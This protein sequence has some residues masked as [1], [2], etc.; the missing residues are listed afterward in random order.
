MQY[1]ISFS[2]RS[3]FLMNSWRT[4]CA[5]YC[6]SVCWSC[7][8]CFNNAAN[9]KILNPSLRPLRF[10]F[11]LYT[12]T[13]L[14]FC[15]AFWNNFT[16]KS[17]FQSKCKQTRRERTVLN[18]KTRSFP[19]TF[20][21]TYFLAKSVLRALKITLSSRWLTV[22]SD[23]Q[24]VKWTFNSNRGEVEVDLVCWFGHFFRNEIVI[25][26]KIARRKSLWQC[27][28]SVLGSVR[29]SSLD[30]SLISIHLIRYWDAM[31]E[32]NGG[33]SI[34]PSD[35]VKSEA[36]KSGWLLKWTNYLKGKR[37]DGERVVQVWLELSHLQATRRDGS[38]FRMESCRI[39][40]ECL[41]LALS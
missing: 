21:F 14:C 29:V 20:S 18:E 27:N 24:I 35:G 40:G 25:I 7:F 32:S 26:R 10:P 4:R 6:L 33:K 1:G 39:T 9:I 36:S 28:R 17:E 34:I 2:S 41:L 11:Y 23:K 31:S 37:D 16:F 19:A 15:R 22:N 5:K 12:T 3:L 13:R 38:F 8:P 30:N